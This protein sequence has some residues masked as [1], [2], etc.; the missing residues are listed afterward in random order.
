MKAQGGLMLFIASALAAASAFFCSWAL[1][2]GPFSAIPIYFVCALMALVPLGLHSLQTMR[3]AKAR[4]I[5][6]IMVAFWL[7]AALSFFWSHDQTQSL[8]HLNSYVGCFLA[9][10]LI[11][12]ISADL[13]WW[14]LIGWAIIAGCA[15]ASAIVVS[16]GAEFVSGGIGDERATIGQLNANYVAYSIA[17]SI[18]VVLALMSSR[19]WPLLLRLLLIAYIGLAGAAVAFS[20]SRGA[21]LAISASL[22]SFFAIRARR[23]LLTSALAL[24]CVVLGVVILYDY[25]PGPVQFRLDMFWDALTVSSGAVDLTGREDIWPY[26]IEAFVS[27]PMLG[28]GVGAFPTANPLH[29]YAHNIPL[30]MLAEIGVV[31][32]LFYF[33]IIA[34]IFHRLFLRGGATGFRGA[35]FALFL[36]WVAIAL[37]GVWEAAAFGW[38]VFGW[39]FAGSEHA[40][41]QRAYRGVGRSSVLPQLVGANDTRR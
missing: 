28:V 19:R 22:L 20:G 29:V 8:Y 1:E 3:M 38:L 15:V 32:F 5:E 30:V 25:L 13:K 7:W 40:R 33:A 41:M 6:L 17:T 27:N 26:A 36:T 39:M 34:I 18:P 21:L 12:R 23:S 24:S 35:G 4:K 9:F 2:V 31:G 10:V 14:R 11:S 37:T 16:K